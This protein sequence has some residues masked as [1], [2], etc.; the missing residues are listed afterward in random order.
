MPR[1]KGIRNSQSGLITAQFTGKEAEAGTHGRTHPALPNNEQK[2]Q[3]TEPQICLASRPLQSW[4]K[5]ERSKS[6]HSFFT[7]SG[8]PVPTGSSDLCLSCTGCPADKFKNETVKGMDV[9]SE[10]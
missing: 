7:M 6:S 5:A 2:E 10:L 3:D 9:H 1:P 4:L 8:S